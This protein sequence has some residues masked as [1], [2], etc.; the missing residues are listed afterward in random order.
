MPSFECATKA[1]GLG[2]VAYCARH[3][4]HVWIMTHETLRDNYRVK[5][6]IEENIR[7]AQRVRVAG[8]FVSGGPADRTGVGRRGR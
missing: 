1:R 8:A 5:W 2:Y 6:M 4:E 7:R 3:P